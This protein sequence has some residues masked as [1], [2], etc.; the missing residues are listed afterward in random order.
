VITIILADPTAT[1][2]AN[3]SLQALPSRCADKFFLELLNV[4]PGIVSQEAVEC[5]T[6]AHN[7][8]VQENFM[9]QRSALKT[10]NG[11]EE[12]KGISA[13]EGEAS[14][15]ND[16]TNDCILGCEEVLEPR[17]KEANGPSMSMREDFIKR[18]M[19]A[20]VH[21]ASNCDGSS[22]K[23]YRQLLERDAMV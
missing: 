7:E 16:C 20:V 8:I 12:S 4:I 9:V 2:S 10:R 19:R 6:E 15:V 1:F 17:R 13:I 21:G 18:V 14:E 22:G 3:V 11:R 23:S 5:A